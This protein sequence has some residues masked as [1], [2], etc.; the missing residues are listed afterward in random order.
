MKQP[1]TFAIALVAAIGFTACEKCADCACKGTYDFTF[2]S[3]MPEADKDFVTEAYNQGLEDDDQREICDKKKDLEAA[4]QVYE[5]QSDSF[6]EN[7][8]YKDNEWSLNATYKCDCV[9]QE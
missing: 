5:A 9:M 4:I 3:A 6:A 7:Q 8:V 2:S 1:M